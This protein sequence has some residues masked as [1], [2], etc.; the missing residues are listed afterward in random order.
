MSITRAMCTSFKQEILQ[1]T[2]NLLT[3]TLK[4][5]LYTSS[6]SLGPGTTAY[7]TMGEVV[8]SGY[9]AGGK[10]LTGV[11]ITSTGLTAMVDFDDVEWVSASF[12][13]RG[14][15][16]YNASKSNKA[17]AVLT[18]GS[19]LTVSGSSFVIT[20]PEVTPSTAILRIQ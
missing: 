8:G 4:V 3:D 12:T 1:G 5:A 9:T 19:D 13:T 11:A 2:H 10:T 7:T 16:I 15:L 14:A 20:M 6:A 17:V 18:F